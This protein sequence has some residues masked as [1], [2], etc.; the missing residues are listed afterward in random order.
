MFECVSGDSLSDVALG[1]GVEGGQFYRV[2]VLRPHLKQ[3]FL[4]GVEL[5]VLVHVVLVDLK[6]KVQIKC[7]DVLQKHIKVRK[8]Q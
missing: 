8:K 3:N 5:I 7:A 1:G 4:K 6:T 2:G